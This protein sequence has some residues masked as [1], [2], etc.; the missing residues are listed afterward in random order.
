MGLRL[1]RFPCRKV[2]WFF[3]PRWTAKIHQKSECMGADL[4]ANP[5][6][7]QYAFPLIMFVL[8]IVPQWLQ[9]RLNAVA[10]IKPLWRC[11]GRHQSP[12]DTRH[13]EHKERPESWR[14]SAGRLPRWLVHGCPTKRPHQFWKALL[15]E[16]FVF[17]D[18]M[19]MAGLKKW[20]VSL[21]R[22]QPPLVPGAGIFWATI[23]RAW[24]YWIGLLHRI[25]SEK[26]LVAQLFAKGLD[27]CDFFYL[28][29]ISRQAHNLRHP[30]P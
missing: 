11:R 12:D 27:F 16:D 3:W 23:G 4:P 2:S 14:V 30:Q 24:S 5:Q 15:D 22:A 10:T 8:A 19:G 9:T 7:L 6:C 13:K 20:F 17:G 18:G 28:P 26:M 29:S 21:E 1:C 25:F